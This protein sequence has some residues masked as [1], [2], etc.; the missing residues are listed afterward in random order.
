MTPGGQNGHSGDGQGWPV[1]FVFL[2]QEQRKVLLGNGVPV[3]HPA[4]SDIPFPD[5]GALGQG[6]DQ[7]E[8]RQAFFTHMQQ[9]ML[10]FAVGGKAQLLLHAKIF[11][12]LANNPPDLRFAARIGQRLRGHG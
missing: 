2:A 11:R 1:R 10:A 12:L 3:L 7:L 9:H 4:K 5:A 8:C 6:A